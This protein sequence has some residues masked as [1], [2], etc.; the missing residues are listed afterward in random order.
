MSRDHLLENLRSLK[1]ALEPDANFLRYSKKFILAAPPHD[2]YVFHT[3]NFLFH[4]FKLA[5]GLGL[6]SL[7]LF[8]IVGG[9]NPKKNN[10]LLA[11]LN[12]KALLKES[13]NATV[14][15]ALDEIRYRQQLEKNIAIVIDEI[16]TQ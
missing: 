9:F 8:I 12:E 11:S 3:K 16:I 6:M 10:D 13:A 1:K 2:P 5:M 7:V 15:I 14:N 4:S